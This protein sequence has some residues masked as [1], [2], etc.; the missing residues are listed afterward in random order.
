[1]KNKMK[2]FYKISL[3]RYLSNQFLLDYNL[4]N[5]TITT[6]VNVKIKRRLC[7]F[8]VATC[9][10]SVQYTRVPKWQTSFYYRQKLN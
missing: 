2:N 3:E 5:K 6:Y 9:I 1:M 4:I 8:R 10:E 7:C